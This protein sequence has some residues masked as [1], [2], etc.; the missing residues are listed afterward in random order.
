MVSSEIEELTR[1]CDRY[2]VMARGRI[3]AELPGTASQSELLA[4]V[5]GLSERQAAA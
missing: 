4:A 1:I 2:L 3:V 5:S